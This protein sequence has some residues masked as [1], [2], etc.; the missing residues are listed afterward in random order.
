MEVQISWPISFSRVCMRRN[1]LVFV[2]LAAMVGVG[3]SGKQ[4]NFDQ[5]DTGG[6]NTAAGA[7]TPGNTLNLESPAEPIGV[8]PNGSVTLKYNAQ[9]AS[10]AALAGCAV[11]LSR[12]ATST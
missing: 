7:T 1:L 11:A 5:T 9:T 10:G 6:A 2:A 3:C 4:G 12:D 8:V